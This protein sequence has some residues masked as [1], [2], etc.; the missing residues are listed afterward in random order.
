MDTKTCSKCGWVVAMRDPSNYCPVCGT[1]FEYRICS[2]CGKVYKMWARRSVC[3]ECYRK[4]VDVGN[5][6]AMIARRRAVYAEWL[7]KVRK[8]PTDYPKLTEEQWMEAV[9]HFNGCA[10]C[11]NESVDTRGY[12]IP[13]KDGGRYC[14]WNVIPLCSDCALTLKTNLN[15]FLGPKRPEGLVDTITYLEVRLNAAIKKSDTVR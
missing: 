10:L 6:K 5:G 13:F 11:K 7:E 8:V 12:F 1:A 4:Y 2:M 15:W 3:K 9:R 14:D